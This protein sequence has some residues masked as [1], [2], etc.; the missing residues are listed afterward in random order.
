MNQPLSVTVNACFFFKPAIVPTEATSIRQ[1]PEPR[2]SPIRGKRN[3][4]KH[5][6]RGK[7]PGKTCKKTLHPP[8]TPASPFPLAGRGRHYPVPPRGDATTLSPPIARRTVG[9]TTAIPIATINTANSYIGGGDPP[10][11][12]CVHELFL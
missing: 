3:N 7:L 8:V 12:K 10:L 11:A 5:H 1:T 9:A 2:T 4:Q 6:A